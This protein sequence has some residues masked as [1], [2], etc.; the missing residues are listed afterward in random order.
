MNKGRINITSHARQ[1][2]FERLPEIHPNNY[3]SFVNSARYNGESMNQLILTSPNIAKYIVSHFSANN[4]TKFKYY[5]NCLFVFSGNKHKARTLVTVINIS[6]SND[7]FEDFD[8][9]GVV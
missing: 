2:L 7:T 4:S 6:N 9:D 8:L 5:R 1:R 3:N